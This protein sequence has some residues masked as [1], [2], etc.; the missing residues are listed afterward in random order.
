M[1]NDAE[2]DAILTRHPT[3]HGLSID[4][5]FFDQA[6]NAGEDVRA[7]EDES[8]L[9]SGRFAVVVRLRRWRR[10]LSLVLDHHVTGFV[11][12][13]IHGGLLEVALVFRRVARRDV[14]ILPHPA[15]GR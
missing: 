1:T 7:V 15:S 6:T 14:E 4:E 8:D 3:G 2:T 9:W 5:T 11:V 13:F 12:V 10:R